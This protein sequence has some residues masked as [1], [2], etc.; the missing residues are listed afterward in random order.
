[1]L[2]SD[3]T[4]TSARHAVGAVILAPDFDQTM[5]TDPKQILISAAGSQAFTLRDCL[6]KLLRS[7]QA[8]IT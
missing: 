7:E 5:S 4:R 3:A 8:S 2:R 1:M 6:E